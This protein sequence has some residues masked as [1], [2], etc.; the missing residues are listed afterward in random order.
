MASKPEGSSG[1]ATPDFASEVQ[2]KGRIGPKRVLFLTNSEHGQANVML[3]AA[4][5]LLVNNPPGSVE[6]HFG[7]FN[8]IAKAVA[9]A[10]DF[11]LREAARAS[12]KQVSLNGD[13]VHCA[14]K[15]LPPPIV[16]HEVQ[17]IP[18]INCLLRP[19]FPTYDWLTLRPGF[20]NTP[21]L[22]KIFV[23]GMFHPWAGSEYVEIFESVK[24]IIDEVRPDLV[25]LDNA[26][27]PGVT[28]VHHL[29]I[30]FILLTPNTIKDFAA[31]IQ[32]WG[33]AFWKYPW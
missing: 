1:T 15:Q 30:R 5:A 18:F 32:P 28:A 21:R 6:V 8:P 11:A 31:G 25:V 22:L 2:E 4:H 9:E 14:G 23:E 3:A 19:E 26:F 17:G 13:T 16:F 27:S 24:A 20:W 33:A 10:S 29:G 7:S 12:S